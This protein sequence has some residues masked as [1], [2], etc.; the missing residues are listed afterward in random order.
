LYYPKGVTVD[1]GGNV[2]F[3]APT[4]IRKVTPDGIVSS[5]AGNGYLGYSGDGGPATDGT[6]NNPTLLAADSAGRIYVADTNNN[7]VRMLT[8]ATAAPSISPAGVVPASSTVNTIQ[9]GQW[10]SI[11]GSKL[12]GTTATWTGNFPTTL[13]GTSVTIDGKPAYLSYVSPT[14]INLQAPDDGATGTVPVAVTTAT[15]TATSTVTLARVA[16]AFLLLDGRHVAGLILRS[17]GSGAYGGGTYD[18]IGP[19]GNSL[20]YPTVAAKAGDV[21]ELFAT[22]C[23][24]T[25]PTV[26]AGQAFAGVAWTVDPVTLK[27][28][29]VSVTPSF[30]GISSTGLY[31]FNLTIPAGLGPGDVSLAVTVGGSQSQTGVVISL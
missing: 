27:L 9:A 14:Q 24:P 26:P 16:P 31:Q 20:G 19:T 12:A 5:I 22:G 30:A 6:L 15:G 10:V 28:G 1:M 13:G 11:Y 3:T 7:A 18:I 8:P 23:G 17:N 4:W 29:G 2:Y 21:I 25:N